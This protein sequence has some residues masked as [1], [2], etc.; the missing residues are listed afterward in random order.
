M[1]DRALVID[2]IIM[3]LAGAVVAWALLSSY[4]WLVQAIGAYLAARTVAL[5]YSGWTQ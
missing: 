1:S 4:G 5:V 3:G 2:A